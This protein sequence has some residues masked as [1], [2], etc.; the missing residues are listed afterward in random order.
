MKSKPV[1]EPGFELRKNEDV[2]TDQI[3]TD[4]NND[5]TADFFKPWHYMHDPVKE[6]RLGFR[7]ENGN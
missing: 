6:L 2:I 5:Y 7:E 1:D 4:G 3:D